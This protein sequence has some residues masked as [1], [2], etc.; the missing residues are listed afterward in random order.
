MGGDDGK[1]A[2]KTHDSDAG[3]GVK[4]LAPFPTVE[5]I[6]DPQYEQGSRNVIQHTVI[7]KVVTLVVIP[8]SIE[9]ESRLFDH[10]PNG[11]IAMLGPHVGH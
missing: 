2:W 1:D 5:S 3:E 8:L 7:G 6:K 11:L 10:V 9:H 4:I